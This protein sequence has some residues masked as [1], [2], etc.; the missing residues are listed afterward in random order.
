MFVREILEVF[1]RQAPSVRLL[2]PC[3]KGYSTQ[4]SR[5]TIRKLQLRQPDRAGYIDLVRRIKMLQQR[6]QIVPFHVCVCFYEYE[7][8]LP[9]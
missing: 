6:K 5:R 1:L 7:P 4:E 3:R 8:L 9:R 2:R